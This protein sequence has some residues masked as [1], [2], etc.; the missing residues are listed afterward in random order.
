MCKTFLHL[1]V[2]YILPMIDIQSWRE[3]VL[4]FRNARA[5]GFKRPSDTWDAA[6]QAVAGIAIGGGKIRTPHPSGRNTGF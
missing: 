5:R 6:A 1:F 3:A 4:R 2:D